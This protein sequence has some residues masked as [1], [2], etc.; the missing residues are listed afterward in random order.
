VLRFGIVPET[1]LADFDLFMRQHGR[2]NFAVEEGYAPSIRGGSLRLGPP[3]QQFNSSTERAARPSA[4]STTRERVCSGGMNLPLKVQRGVAHD[5]AGRRGC[6][7]LKRRRGTH[8]VVG[9]VTGGHTR[10]R[11]QHTARG[12]TFSHTHNGWG[13]QR[14]FHN[15]ILFVRTILRFFATESDRVRAASCPGNRG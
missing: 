9:R 1:I 13:K 5:H 11:L 10:V 2:A 3:T 15:T 12:R 7:E 8:T 6:K 4:T 14:A